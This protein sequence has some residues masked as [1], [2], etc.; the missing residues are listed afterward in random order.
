MVDGGEDPISFCCRRRRSPKSS[1]AAQRAEEGLSD[2]L[3]AAAPR[4]AGSLSATVGST[5]LVRLNRVTQG[6][7]A[8]VYAKLEF[9]SA[10]GSVKDRIAVHMIEAAE[11]RGEINPESSV[12]VEATSG[13]TGVGIAM[14]AA[15]KGYRCIISMP[16]TP[17]MTE[18]YMLCRAYGAE[19]YLSDPAEGAKGF[20]KLAEK[21]AETTPGAYLMR[22]FTNDDNVE[23]HYTG[24]GPEIWAQTSGRIDV[25]VAG[26]GTGGSLVGI[27]RY[28]KEKKPRCHMVCVEAAESRVLAGLDEPGPVAHGLVGISAGILLP[29]I[30]KEVQLCAE[31][32]PAA[33]E[34]QEGSRYPGVI[35]EFAQVPSS[36]GV[37]MAKR[38]AEQ[39]GL[40][41][42]P[43]SGAACVAA[44]EL[45]KKPERKGQVIVVV[46]PSSGS[47]YMQ[48]PMFDRLRQEAA[49]E[50]PW[51]NFCSSENWR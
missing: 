24:T 17:T 8:E 30:D 47:R 51:C 14:I 15:A 13:N 2:A 29:L 45:A 49:R 6:C 37:A 19:V 32:Q 20:V 44:L 9:I 4:L 28:L 23:A 7:S 43:S 26:A 35:D 36:R 11:A 41:V 40:L 18:R 27:G 31:K 25:L 39:E 21:I 48:H 16:R 10:G 33:Q 46:F 50:L 1:D 34:T 12:L 38:L 5:P 3:A 42:G 22:Q